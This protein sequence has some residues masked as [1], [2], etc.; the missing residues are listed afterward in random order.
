MCDYQVGRDFDFAEISNAFDEIGVKISTASTLIIGTH[1]SFLDTEEISMDNIIAILDRVADS[2]VRRIIIETHYTTV[3]EYMLSI[4]KVKLVNKVVSLEFGLET[5]NSFVQENCYNKETSLERL[6]QVISLV[7]SY[8]IGVTLNVLVG[9]P[10]LTTREQL[11]DVLHTVKWAFCNGANYVVLFPI[12]IKLYTLLEYLY[13]NN[14]YEPISQWLLIEI[15]NSFDNNVLENIG[16]SWYGNREFRYP[17]SDK[18]IVFPKTCFACH[19]DIM[20]FYDQFIEVRSASQRKAL[21]GTIINKGTKCKCRSKVLDDLEAE[22]TVSLPQ[23]V[24]S[25]HKYIENDLLTDNSEY[26]EISGRQDSEG[27]VLGRPARIGHH[28]HR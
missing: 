3:N 15:L 22:S 2:S 27:I 18:R 17:D 7:H 16:L 4:I 19:D 20:N 5:T 10:F 25:E 8:D 21:I 13:R 6:K 14:R 11:D 24:C 12:N 9:A 23:R 26:T 1:G 28:S